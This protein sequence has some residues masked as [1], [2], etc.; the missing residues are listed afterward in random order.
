MEWVCTL[1]PTGD[2]IW[3]STKMIKNTGTAFISGLT[4]EFTWASGCVESSTDLEFTKQLIKTMQPQQSQSS[5][6]S[7]KKV[8]A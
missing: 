1:G 3:E 8:N 6:A 5:M 2:V 4:E 7:G